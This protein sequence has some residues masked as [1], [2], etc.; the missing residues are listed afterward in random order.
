MSVS[1][2]PDLIR[3]TGQMGD[4]WKPATEADRDALRDH[5]RIKAGTEKSRTSRQNSAMWLYCTMLADALNDAGYD[6]RTFPW[7]EGMELPFTKHSVMEVFWRPVMEA[8]A[9]KDSTTE[10]ITT[11]VMAVYEALSRAMAQKVGVAVDWPCIET[12]M[13]N[14][15]ER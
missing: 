3:C 13:R 10:Q 7:R 4:Y 11:D 5:A 1:S 12:Q 8:M 6:M 15:H 2:M 14:Y 9:G